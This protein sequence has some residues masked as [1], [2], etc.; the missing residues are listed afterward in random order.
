MIFVFCSQHSL[1]NVTTT[2]RLCGLDVPERLQGLDVSPMLDDPSHAV[3]DTAFCVNGKGF[4]LRDDRWAY[5][6]Y[7]EDGA[8]GAE[9]YDMHVDPAQLSSLAGDETHAETVAALRDRLAAKLDAVRANDLG[10]GSK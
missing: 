2:S 3:R 8:K 5:I 9:L 4:L 1:S 7:G 6:Q 10:L